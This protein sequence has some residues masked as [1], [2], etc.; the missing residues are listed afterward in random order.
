MTDLKLLNLGCGSRYHTEW[1]NID[2][3]S[4]SKD[5]I[6]HDLLKGI[7]FPDNTFDAVYHSH[8]LEHF[9]KDKATEFIKECFR[10]LKPNGIIRIVVP[11][12]E[13]IVENYLK[14]MRDAM[15]GV[16]GADKNYDWLMLELYDQ[17]VRN[18]SG[19]EMA[20]YLQQDNISNE[21]FVHDRIGRT[22][23][24]IRKSYSKYN[25]GGINVIKQSTKFFTYFLKNNITVL[26]YR[27][28]KLFSSDILPKYLQYIKID[29]FR[30]SG[31]I[32]Q[33]MY[34][35]YSLSRL[36]KESGFA[37]IK[38][39][40]AIESDIPNWNFYGLFDGHDSVSLIVEAYKMEGLLK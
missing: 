6:A 9:P 10:V 31:E 7:P 4:Q 1:I 26:K 35:R 14:E 24:E 16:E 25:N 40:T 21:N 17:V 19:G 39:K 27:V 22:Y 15:V 29:K 20:K 33:W 32:H 23:V 8:V 30:S 11:N 18:Q 38:V 12:L 28:K 34:D 2:F 36:L 13:N 3:V 5:V 37:E